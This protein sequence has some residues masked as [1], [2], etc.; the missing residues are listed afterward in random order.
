MPVLDLIENDPVRPATGETVEARI[1]ISVVPDQTTYSE[2][3]FAEMERTRALNRLLE[4]LIIKK[5]PENGFSGD[6]RF[7]NI[8]VSNGVLFSHQLLA[9]TQR[10][11]NSY[12]NQFPKDAGKRRRLGLEGVAKLALEEDPGKPG[13]Y[14]YRGESDPKPYCNFQAAIE[15]LDANGNRMGRWMVELRPVPGNPDLPLKVE[16]QIGI[17]HKMV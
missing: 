6:A 4:E 17:R 10:S 9:A 5:V 8:N 2:L 11:L 12:L 13:L 15:R 7:F 14:Y 1:Y 16:I 3:G